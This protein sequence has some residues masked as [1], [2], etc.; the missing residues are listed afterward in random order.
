M[1]KKLYYLQGVLK[2]KDTFQQLVWF[3]FVGA[4]FAGFY[5]VLATILMDWVMLPAWS[6]TMLAYLLLITPAYLS[7]KTL[8]FKYKSKTTTAFSRYMFLQFS[9]LFL[10]GIVAH[11]LK[12]TTDSPTLLISLL[13]ASAAILYN[14]FLLKIWVF[15][16]K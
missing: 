12:N 9:T 2:E 14:F 3:L 13:S 4:I 6:A 5:I 16:R 8:V 11:V 1:A 10:A 7:Q 15:S